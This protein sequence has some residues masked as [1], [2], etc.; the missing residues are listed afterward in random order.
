MSIVRI[1]HHPTNYKHIGE[2]VRLEVSCEAFFHSYNWF[3]N[4]SQLKFETSY[5]LEYRC[6]R[7]STYGTY[8]CTYLDSDNIRYY[9]NFPLMRPSHGQHSPPRI[10]Q[11]SPQIEPHP[12]EM[13]YISQ[14]SHIRESLEVN[15]H[16][17]C[18]I[19]S[20]QYNHQNLPT[21]TPPNIFVQYYLLLV[22]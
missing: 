7:V 3:K 13:Y 22:L 19:E 21:L 8:L 20:L 6:I 9:E 10:N 4:N 18:D 17:C 15:H 2:A 1:R 16:G 14:D 11:N 5:K 12:S